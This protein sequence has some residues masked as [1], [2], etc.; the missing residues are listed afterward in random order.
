M[1]CNVFCPL[2][3][4][5][6]QDAP[7]PEERILC[8]MSHIGLLLCIE[9]ASTLE[10]ISSVLCPMPPEYTSVA[11]IRA[12][13]QECVPCIM[14]LDSDFYYIPACTVHSRGTQ[15][16]VLCPVSLH[17]TEEREPGGYNMYYVCAEYI[18]LCRVHKRGTQEGVL[19]PVSLTSAHPS[20]WAA[21][22]PHKKQTLSVITMKVIKLA[23]LVTTGP[24]RVEARVEL[25]IRRIE[26]ENTKRS[27]ATKTL[28]LPLSGLMVV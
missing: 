1:H 7:A 21:D 15:D 10:A 16:G 17:S 2:D 12:S 27:F 23:M 13:T 24:M 4:Y 6:T 19:C 3:F 26:M 5:Y 20:Q 25:D 22:W 14:S 28:R 11:Q 18:C 9:Y 8:H